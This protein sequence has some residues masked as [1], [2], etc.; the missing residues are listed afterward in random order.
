M[1]N[2]PRPAAAKTGTTDNYRDTWTMGY[3]PNLTVGVWVG[4]TD[5]RPMK[6][7][8]SSM[9]AGKIWRESMDTAHRLPPVA[10]RGVPAPARPGGRLHL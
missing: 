6:E 5:N 9:S 1:L 10:G 8:L 2:M 7:V 3:T 4:N